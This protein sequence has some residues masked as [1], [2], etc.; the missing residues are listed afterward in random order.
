TLVLVYTGASLPLLLL[1]MNNRTQP[2]INLINFQAV[3]EEI[4]RTLVGS[5]SLV[6]SIPI[7]TFIACYYVVKTRK[8]LT[9]EKHVH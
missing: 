5:V 4:V 6:L 2:V 7:T 3:A 1:F 9:G 8:P